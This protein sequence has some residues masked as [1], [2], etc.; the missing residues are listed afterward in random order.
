[1]LHKLRDFF[2]L[3]KKKCVRLIAIVS[4][5]VILVTALLV[6]LLGAGNPKTVAK[7]FVQAQLEGDALAM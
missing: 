5:A 3:N 4:A 2:V 6:I 7:K 1:M